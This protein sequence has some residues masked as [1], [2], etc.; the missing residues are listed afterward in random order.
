[1]RGKQ[2]LVI[3]NQE[4]QDAVICLIS[5]KGRHAGTICEFAVLGV[6]SISIAYWSALNR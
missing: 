2:R 4:W 6:D 1:M 3:I 5:K